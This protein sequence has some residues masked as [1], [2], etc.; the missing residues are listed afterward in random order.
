LLLAVRIE[1]DLLDDILP[2]YRRD[3]GVLLPLAG[4][5]ELLELDVRVDLQRKVAEGTLQGKDFLLDAGVIG[6]RLTIGGRTSPLPAGEVEARVDDIYVVAKPPTAS[7]NARASEIVSSQKVAARPGNVARN[8]P[9]NLPSNQG[10][11]PLASLSML[12][13]PHTIRKSRLIASRAPGRT[14]RLV[15]TPMQDAWS[16]AGTPA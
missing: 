8:V 7:T 16:S 15:F 11:T 2:A 4:L 13:K 12:A 6:G 10:G 9:P 1:R 3:L 5:A 14:S